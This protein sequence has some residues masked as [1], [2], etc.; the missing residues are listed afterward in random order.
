MVSFDPVPIIDIPELGD[1]AAIRACE[2][3]KVKTQND[4][5]GLALAKERCYTKG[6]YEGVLKVGKYK[7]YKV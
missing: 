5:K 1:L 7:G 3:F 4:A 6:F 2:E